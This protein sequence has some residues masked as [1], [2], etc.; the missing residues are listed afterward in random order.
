MTAA[1]RLADVGSLDELYAQLAPLSINAGWNKPTPSLWDEP[2][3]TFVPYAW[4]YREGKA[5][6]TA[7]GRLIDTSL[8]ER[9]NLI[10]VNPVEGN[11]YATS[12]TI[13]AAYQ[14]ILPGERARAHRHTPNALRL[15]VD[16][17]PGT[18]TVVDGER[19]TM[20]PGDVVLTPAWSWHGHGNDARSPAYWIDYL[21]APLVQALEPMFFEPYPGGF[22]E[23]VRDVETS[24]ALYRWQ[25][26]GPRVAAAAQDPSGRYGRI[27]PLTTG[28]RLATLGLSMHGLDV[29]QTTAPVRTT[30]NGI[31]SVV[32]GS[33]WSEID[34]ERF[35]WERGD[36]VVA[37]AWRPHRHHADAEAVLFRVTDEPALASLGLLRES[38]A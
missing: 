4:R 17:D 34:G 33:G 6:L 10:L 23:T 8:A 2:R 19:M 22:E 26:V 1:V 12:R 25:D 13:V 16:V 14:A 3:K 35:P 36:V 11:T 30:A 21:D 28:T 38:P 27:V 15:I 20:A 32:R 31:Y 37:P 18:Y 7:A 5:A 29:G 9:R 24:P